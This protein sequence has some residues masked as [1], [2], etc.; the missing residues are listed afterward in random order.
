M[1]YVRGQSRSHK[2][3]PKHKEQI[4]EKQK[5]FACE[6]WRNHRKLFTQLKKIDETTYYVVTVFYGFGRKKPLENC[7]TIRRML[8]RRGVGIT[9]DMVHAYKWAGLLLLGWEGPVDER[10]KNKAEA[11]LKELEAKTK[12]GETKMTPQEE[13]A[14]VKA[15]LILKKESDNDFGSLLE[16][17]E[18]AYTATRRGNLYL[19]GI[20]MKI[21]NGESLTD[22]MNDLGVSERFVITVAGVIFCFAWPEKMTERL[23]DVRTE[24]LELKRMLENYEHTQA[25]KVSVLPPSEGLEDTIHE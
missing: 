6:I 15:A 7:E 20:F 1:K 9:Y 2:R 3:K 23:G 17:I 12:E 4:L 8:A 16:K 25:Q 24:Y 21:T 18:L 13:F 14:K 10:Y 19:K 5:I 22:I 11:L